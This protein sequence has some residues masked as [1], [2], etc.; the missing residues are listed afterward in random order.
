M[1][2][3]QTPVQRVS[4]GAGSLLRSSFGDPGLNPRLDSGIAPGSAAGRK[5]DRLHEL[6]GAGQAVQGRL[7]EPGKR[8]DFGQADQAVRLCLIGAGVAVACGGVLLTS[9]TFSAPSLDD[10][11]KNEGVAGVAQG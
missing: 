7:F 2:P 4:C 3:V 6:A 1:Q 9:C 11:R 5:P 10:G 8:L